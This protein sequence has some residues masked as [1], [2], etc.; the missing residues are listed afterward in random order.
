LKLP[1][2]ELAVTSRIPA[3]QTGSNLRKDFSSSTRCTVA[4]FHGFGG[5]ESVASP[6]FITAALSSH[7]KNENAS[8]E[9]LQ[10]QI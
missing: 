5:L 2:C 7:L 6:S 9:I 1:L 3:A 10:Q 4:I 8:S